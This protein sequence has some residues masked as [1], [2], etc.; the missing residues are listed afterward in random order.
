[1]TYRALIGPQVFSMALRIRLAAMSGWAMN[2]AC[3]S[4][5]ELVLAARAR[6]ASLTADKQADV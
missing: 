3:H 6:L 2:A 1:M 4:N 5:E